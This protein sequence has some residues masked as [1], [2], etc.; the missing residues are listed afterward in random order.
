VINAITRSGTSQ[1]HGLAYDY[2]R[3]NI[4]NAKNWF[5]TSVTPLRQNQFG[6][7]FG[8]PI[9]KTVNHG[10]FFLSY[11]GIRIIQPANVAAS[12]L[13]T[14]TAL[15]RLGDFRSTPRAFRPNISCLGVQ[16]LI[17]AN[18]LDPVAQNVL[19]FVPLGDSNPG[20]NYGHPREQATGA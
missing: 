19:K 11:Q 1:Y 18:L 3:N 13:I 17:C 6:G 2:L 16:Y 8:G 7:N 12:S 10:F 20:T 15:E 4:F 14:P 9:P 5:L